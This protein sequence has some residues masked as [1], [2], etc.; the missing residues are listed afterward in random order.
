MCD[1]RSVHSSFS[2]KSANAPA[3]FSLP[4]EVTGSGLLKRRGLKWWISRRLLWLLFLL[5]RGRRHNR[6]VLERVRG[7]PLVVFPGVFHPGLFL[8]TTLL[9]DAMDQLLLKADSSVL[10]MGTG[11]GICAIFAAMKGAK[12]TAIDISPLAVRCARVNVAINDVEDRVR[13]LQGDLFLPVEREKFDLV[14][15]NPPYY[16]GRPRGWPEYAWRGE[17]VVHRFIEGLPKHLIDGGKALL[18]LSTELDLYS[19]REKLKESGLAALEVG[20]R[21]LPGEIMFVYEC[22]AWPVEQTFRGQTGLKADLESA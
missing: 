5:F 14:I 8:S 6:L 12:E 22:V 4:S 1:R 16:E 7:I 3:C 17:N 19:V 15:F 11:T 10:D 2:V 21:R 9:L 18:S 20:R 13:V